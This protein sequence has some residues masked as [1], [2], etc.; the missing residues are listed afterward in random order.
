M[1]I[2][3]RRIN[4]S[5]LSKFT[6]TALVC[7][8]MTTS[9]A[10]LA[11]ADVIEN[12]EFSGTAT[13]VDTNCSSFG[14]G[15]LTGTYSLDVT[16]Q[17]I[18]GPW[19]F[20]TP[21][22]VIASSDAGASAAVFFRSGDNNPGFEDTTSTPPFLQFVQF[23]FPGAD[24]QEIGPL[25]TTT[26]SGDPVLAGGGD[27]CINNAGSTS[28]DPDYAVAGAT[29]LTGTITTPEPSSLIVLGVAMLGLMGFNLKKSL[30]TK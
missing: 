30:V 21:F 8:L 10:A 23:Y 14:S 24:N 5:N 26:F 15:P 13:C 11:R 9:L 28:C 27:A 1:A 2:P 20:S 6:P 3:I 7:M 4:M 18:V 19:S 25:D 29:R 16:M 17:T 12:L 22:G